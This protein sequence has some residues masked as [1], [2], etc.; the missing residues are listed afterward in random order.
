MMTR[1]TIAIV[2]LTGC[3]L[4]STRARR[5]A[6]PT[7]TAS[8]SATIRTCQD[9]RVRRVG[10]RPG[11]LL[12]RRRRRRRTSSRTSARPRRRFS[13]TTARAS[14]CATTPR[15]RG[16]FRRRYPRPRHV[17]PPPVNNEPMPTINCADVLANS[18]TSPARRT[19]RRWSRPCSRCL[20]PAAPSYTAVFAP[21][22]SC[23]G[24]ASI[25]DPD[26]TKHKSRRQR[27]GRTTMRSSTT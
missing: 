2:A 5:N 8:T 3:S 22:T 23:K 16:R 12:L 19:C 21:Q 15:C 14:A 4:I 13:S 7:P 1:I 20:Q 17:A 9:G 24:A 25:Y 6:R 27:T 18:S 10:A 11:R 26:P